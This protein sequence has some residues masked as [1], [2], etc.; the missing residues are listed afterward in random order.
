MKKF[1]RILIIFFIF[2]G[3]LIFPKI[4]LAQ[5]GLNQ[6]QNVINQGQN[7]LNDMSNAVGS[8]RNAINDLKPNNNNNNQNYNQSQSPNNGVQQQ[9][10]PEGPYQQ[11]PDY[12]PTPS[13]PPQQYQNQTPPTQNN[14]TTQNIN[15]MNFIT[16]NY[17][18]FGNGSEL[19]PFNSNNGWRGS[20]YYYFESMESASPIE[21][22]CQLNQYYKA[23][24]L[25]NDKSLPSSSSC[26]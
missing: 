26:N 4:S 21:S 24:Y 15:G 17:K 19:Q 18:G 10:V 23:I 13:A 12:Q 6:L 11:Q 2:C 1:F 14:S 9:N 3:M 22:T 8:T 5:G 7:F 20:G 16:T 25:T